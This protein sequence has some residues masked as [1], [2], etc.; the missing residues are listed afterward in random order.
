MTDNP[1]DL[2]EATA[3]IPDDAFVGLSDETKQHLLV[4]LSRVSERAYRRGARHALTLYKL[5][6]HRV[7]EDVGTWATDVDL[8]HTAFLDGPLLLPS[9]EFY[10]EQ[11]QTDLAR[12]GLLEPDR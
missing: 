9:L 6:P 11:F 1:F 8:S 10:V 3:G 5:A 4:L 2:N 12:I 7:P